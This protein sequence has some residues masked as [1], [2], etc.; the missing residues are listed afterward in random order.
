MEFQESCGIPAK[1]PCR[2]ASRTLPGARSH[3][4]SAWP[5]LPVP[6]G[7]F[8]EEGRALANRVLSKADSERI[9]HFLYGIS[10]CIPIKSWEMPSLTIC[11][12]TQEDC[13]SNA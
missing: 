3:A 5:G 2:T 4:E 9:Y 1:C 8:R 11:L 10:T 7:F 13:C 6:K 12:P